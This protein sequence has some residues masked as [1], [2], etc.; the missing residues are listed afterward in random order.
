MTLQGK[1]IGK[2]LYYIQELDQTFTKEY[3]ENLTNDQFDMFL[4]FCD[5]REVERVYNLVEGVSCV[6]KGYKIV[7]CLMVMGV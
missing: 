5:M 4:S 3:I 6:G 2:G 1:H 7:K